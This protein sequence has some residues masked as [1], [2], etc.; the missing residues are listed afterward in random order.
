MVLLA[1]PR[2]PHEHEPCP[3][4]ARP[5]HLAVD[6][7]RLRA[8][9]SCRGGAPRRGVPGGGAAQRRGSDGA[10]SPR[11]LHAGPRRRPT[12]NRNDLLESARTREV[13]YEIQAEKP[14]SQT[15]RVFG[16]TA[17]V[18]ALL[19]LKGTNG[20]KSFERQLWFSDTYVRTPDG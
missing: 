9:R 17:V 2:G 7:R 8:E 15:V 6:G 10:D 5:V 14:G 13:V 4:V 1:S 11:G 19:V 18:T 12:F 3:V 20:G 16:D